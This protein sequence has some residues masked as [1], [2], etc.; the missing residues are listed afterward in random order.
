MFGNNFFFFW[1]SWASEPMGSV[2]V[3]CG[4]CDSWDLSSPIR[5]ES[6]SP[7]LEGRFLTTGPPGKSLEIFFFVSYI[8][9]FHLYHPFLKEWQEKISTHSADW[10]AVQA[11]WKCFLKKL[12]HFSQS[13]SGHHVTHLPSIVELPTGQEESWKHTWHLSLSAQAVAS[14]VLVLERVFI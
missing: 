7:A 8:F 10:P 3:A 13:L 5:I 1:L 4:P 2:V 6:T 11:L 12:K 9:Y 14:C